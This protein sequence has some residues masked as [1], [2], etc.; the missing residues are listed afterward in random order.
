MRDSVKSSDEAIERVLA[1]LRDVEAPVGMER[2]IL[3]GLEERAA[4]RAGAGWRSFGSFGRGVPVGYAVC[5]VVGVILFAL[6][7]PAVRRFGQGPVQSRMGATALKPVAGMP[8]AVAIKDKEPV[9][10]LPGLRFAKSADAGEGQFVRGDDSARDS[11]DGLAESEMRAASFPAP[12]MPL[13]EQERLLLRLAHRNDPVELAML[14]PKLRELQDAQEKAE[15]QRF[16]ARPVV[17]AVSGQPADA[18]TTDSSNDVDRLKTDSVAEQT[19]PQQS[20]P[21]KAVQDLTAEPLAAEQPTSEKVAPRTTTP[22]TE[23]DEQ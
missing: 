16:F 23:P 18:A 9:L 15:F 6:A 19:M 4:R 2:R 11:E 1:G 13:T 8:S 7:I 20:E 3:D 12:P 21:Q 22:Q 14:D 10:H 5:G 17:K